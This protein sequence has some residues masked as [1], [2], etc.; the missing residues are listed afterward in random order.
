[1][2][3]TAKMGSMISRMDKLMDGVESAG[4]SRQGPSS[5]NQL[6]NRLTNHPELDNADVWNECHG[7]SH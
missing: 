2:D 6:T 4:A 7:S 1:M 5:S 3:E